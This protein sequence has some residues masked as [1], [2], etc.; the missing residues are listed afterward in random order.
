MASLSEPCHWVIKAL[1][2]DSQLLSLILGNVF[3]TYLSTP[4]LL[5]AIISGFVVANQSQRCSYMD[6]CTSPSLRLRP[7]R[8]GRLNFN[9][10]LVLPRN[11]YRGHPLPRGSKFPSSQL[12]NLIA[13]YHFYRAPSA[14]FLPRVKHNDFAQPVNVGQDLKFYYC[15]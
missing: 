6:A 9:F 11:Q 7:D 5:S 8:C 14:V 12:T 1:I 13:T 2:M 3:S 10:P 15:I 4:A